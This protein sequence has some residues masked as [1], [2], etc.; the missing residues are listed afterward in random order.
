MDYWDSEEPCCSNLSP[1]GFSWIGIMNDPTTLQGMGFFQ[2]FCVVFCVTSREKKS[3]L[4]P[5]I[6]VPCVFLVGFK[7]RVDLMTLTF[8]FV[9]HLGDV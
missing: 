5:S 1:L 4:K 9:A 6:F 8:D 2:Y 7:E 3:N